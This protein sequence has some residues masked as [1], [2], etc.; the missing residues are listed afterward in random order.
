MEGLLKPIA[1]GCPNLKILKCE[2]FNCPSSEIC[3]LLKCKK[4]Q[5][6]SY[7]HRGLVSAD[8]FKA[9]NE[10]T[11]LKRLTFTDVNID[12]PL[13]EIPPITQLRNLQT[14]E[15]S[16]CSFPMVKKIPVTLFLETLPYLS[17]IGI[18]YA[19]G[20]INDLMNK[21]LLKSPSLKYLDL[22]GN[23]ELHCRGLRNIRR[24]KMLKY[25]DVSLCIRVGKK[26]MK[27]VAEGCPDLQHLNVSGIPISDSMFRQI[28]RCRNLECLLMKDCDIRGINLKRTSTNISD[29]LQLHIGPHLELEEDVIEEMKQDM[30][31]LVVRDASGTSNASECS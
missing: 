8:F 13:H 10:C 15:I 21:I 9:I 3:Y 1:D 25:L 19:E 18:P 12:G 17:Y 28:L 26:A 11:N 7:D 20:N 4:H 24:C 16:C 22:E 31:H 2:A 27:Y 29:L 5:L 23:A 14:L 30:P 6:V